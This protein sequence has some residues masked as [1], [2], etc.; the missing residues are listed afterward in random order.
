MICPIC[1]HDAPYTKLQWERR[2]R[3]LERN[4]DIDIY[5]CPDC[6]GTDYMLSTVNIDQ[7]PLPYDGMLAPPLSPPTGT[8]E[9]MVAALKRAPRGVGRPPRSLWARLLDWFSFRRSIKED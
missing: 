5:P 4:P 8:A 6:G 1:R 3:E 9:A 7:P 2:K